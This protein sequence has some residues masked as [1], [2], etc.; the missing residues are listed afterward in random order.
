VEPYDA[1]ADGQ[2][3]TRRAAIGLSAG[4]G[5]GPL[6]AGFLAQYAPEPL[7]VP[8][9]GHLVVIAVAVP[10]MWL[11]PE[12]VVPDRSSPLMARLQ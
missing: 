10:L 9:L 1:G 2:V 7:V 11:A 5:L 12:T 3:G 8:Y 6:T 4:F